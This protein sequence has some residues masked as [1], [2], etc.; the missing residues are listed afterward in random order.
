MNEMP[1]VPTGEV[2]APGVLPASDPT[3]ESSTPTAK[4][5]RAWPE[6]S[7]WTRPLLVIPVALASL[8]A[9]MAAADALGSGGVNGV[10]AEPDQTPVA[11]PPVGISATVETTV[12]EVVVDEPLASGAVEQGDS[13][14]AEGLTRVVT[15]GQ[16]GMARVTYQV[17]FVRGVQVGRTVSQMVVLTPAID[18]V[19]AVGTLDVPDRDAI[20]PGSNREIGQTMAADAGFVGVEWS[21]LD[22][23]WARESNWRHLAENSSSGAYGIPQAL[24][25]SKMAAFG[26]DWET[27]PATQI[28]W[29]L[30]YITGRYGTPCGAW[31]SFSLRSPHWY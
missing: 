23:L 18:G 15:A 27:N 13:S 7:G 17:L 8:V 28:A 30:S 9:G 19:V 29:G 5:G 22:N 26:D 14:L 24:P 10:A 25:G 12:I 6:W 3:V 1:E 4:H 2:L 31:T 11:S 20:E 21:C 16:P